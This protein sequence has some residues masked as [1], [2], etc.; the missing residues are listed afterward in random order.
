M[1]NIVMR[2]LC[3]LGLL[4]LTGCGEPVRA[5]AH[6]PNM[7]VADGVQNEKACPGGYRLVTVRNT[8]IP[9]CGEP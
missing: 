6:W 3:L 7:P 5:A 4:A 9:V 1:R 8:A 2:L